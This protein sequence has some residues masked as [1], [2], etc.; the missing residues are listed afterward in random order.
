[1]LD[2]FQAWWGRRA[3]W[4]KIV[5]IIVAIYVVFGPFISDTPADKQDEV[6]Q[7]RHDDER[8]RYPFNHGGD[9]EVYDRYHRASYINHRRRS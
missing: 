4:Q 5:L 8:H 3:R 7:E 9:R 2:R 1:M 6:A